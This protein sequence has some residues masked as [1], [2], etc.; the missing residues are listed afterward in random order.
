MPIRFKVT[1]DNYKLRHTPRFDDT[2]YQPWDYDT[3]KPGG[4]VIA[5][6]AKYTQG[7]ATGYKT[8]K[9]GRQWW[10][11]EIDERSILNNFKLYGHEEFPTKIIGWVSS[12]FL[13]KQ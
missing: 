3:S 8:D 12:T 7:Y 6:L 4:N 1:I 10:Y 5:H 2:S 9:S 11:V 13:E